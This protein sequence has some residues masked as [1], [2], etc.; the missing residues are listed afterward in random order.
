MIYCIGIL[1]G[2]IRNNQLLSQDYDLDVII[3]CDDY[4]RVMSLQSQFK[5]RGYTLYGKNNYMPYTF[6]GKLH[7]K[8]LTCVSIRLYNDKTH[9]YLEFYESYIV[10]GY[11]VNKNY[12]YYYLLD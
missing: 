11:N 12:D 6:F 9:Y 10:E 5:S 7:K 4:E 1:L 3:N 2:Y 8:Y